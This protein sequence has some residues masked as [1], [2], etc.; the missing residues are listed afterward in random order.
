[1]KKRILGRTGIGVSELCLGTMNFGWAT[2]REESTAILDRYHAA[3]GNFILC[4]AG[5]MADGRTPDW[6]TL[7]ET[8]VGEWLGHAPARREDLLVASTITLSPGTDTAQAATERI[9]AACAASLRRLRSDHIDL[10]VCRWHPALAPL[11]PVVAGLTRL[12][13]RGAIRY[14]GF[15]GFPLWRVVESV[16]LAQRENLCRLEALQTP[17]SLLENA[18]KQEQTFQVCADYRV[19]FLAQSPLADGFLASRNLND[20]RPADART[21]R[22]QALYGH[23]RGLALLAEVEAIARSRGVS[24]AAVA[25]AW[26]L[27]NAQVTTAV[28]G[29]QHPWQIDDAV[30]AAGLTLTARECERL[31]VAAR[32]HAANPGERALHARPAT[33]S[34]AHAWAMRPLRREPAASAD[35]FAVS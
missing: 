1:M 25:L 5:D 15:A 14:F 7:P 31:R 13:Q 32:N 9:A 34:R 35:C 17:Y 16:A 27:D 19:S 21:R 30:T 10:L 6:T 23:A 26:V 4:S 18:A 3:G 22:L 24:P 33:S 8:Y 11:E 2:N 12:V 20:A 29:A 28:L